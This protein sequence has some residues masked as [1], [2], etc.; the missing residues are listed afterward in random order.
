MKVGDL[1]KL[2]A[3]VTRE[4]ADMLKPDWRVNIGLII[5]IMHC[6]EEIP[7]YRSQDSMFVLWHDGTEWIWQSDLEVINE[8]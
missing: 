8:V 7:D 5:R 3:D 1:V 6:K 2:R 4:L